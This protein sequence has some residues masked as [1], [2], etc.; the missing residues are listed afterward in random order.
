M[1][2]A[3][4]GM[5]QAGPR[6][7]EVRL[8]RGRSL[9]DVAGKA[10]ITKGFLSL[11]ERGLTRVSVP[12]LLAVCA[13]LDISIGSLFVSR[14][15][16]VPAGAVVGRGSPLQMGGIDI[17]EYLL[18]ASDQPHLQVMRTELQPG[19]GSGG[20]YRLDTETIFAFVL[21]GALTIVIDGEVRPLGAGESTSYP[22][23]A[24]HEWSNPSATQPAEVLWVFAPP[25]STTT[26]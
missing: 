26:A 3:G 18:T 8:R 6:L 13:A 5:D 20:A 1:T 11:A 17:T 4:T 12:N 23:K 21:A 22:A 25:L 7:R 14:E 15:A 19:G 10:G 24:L 9:A 16:A 2:A